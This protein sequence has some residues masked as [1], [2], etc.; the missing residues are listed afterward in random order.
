MAL[1]SRPATS[2][3][4]CKILQKPDLTAAD[5]VLTTLPG[6]SGLNRFFGTSA[7]APHAGAIAAQILSDRPSLTPAE[8]RAA[9]KA[10]F[11]DIEATGFDR[12]LDRESS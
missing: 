11:F 9:M 6:T 7:A 3:L 5:G 10:S 1:R 2:V 8:V 4:R 12:Y